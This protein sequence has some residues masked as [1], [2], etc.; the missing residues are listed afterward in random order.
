MDEEPLRRMTLR[1]LQEAEVLKSEGTR[2]M[3]QITDRAG[4]DAFPVGGVFQDNAGAVWQKIRIKCD[5]QGH[6]NPVDSYLMMGGDKFTD[7]ARVAQWAPLTVL[8]A[9]LPVKNERVMKLHRRMMVTMEMAEALGI[10]DEDLPA[11]SDR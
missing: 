4:L 9:E 11:V 1:E 8:A 3:E 2:K 6:G 5:D 10:V 7:S